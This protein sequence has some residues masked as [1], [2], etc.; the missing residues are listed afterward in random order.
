MKKFNESIGT[1]FGTTTVESLRYQVNKA[2]L[3]KSSS[4]NN[5]LSFE[6]PSTCLENAVGM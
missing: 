6:S 2:Y 4:H 5:G 3:E 1:I